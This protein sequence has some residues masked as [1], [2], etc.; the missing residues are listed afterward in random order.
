MLIQKWQNFTRLSVRSHS[1]NARFE[2][3]FTLAFFL[4]CL[5]SGWTAWGPGWANAPKEYFFRV[6]RWNWRSFIGPM[7]VGKKGCLSSS[8]GMEC[9]KDTKCIQTNY[10]T[11]QDS[12]TI[13]IVK[14]SKHHHVDRALSALSL[15]LWA[16]AYLNDVA[17]ERA[18][19]TLLFGIV[20]LIVGQVPGVLHFRLGHIL[21]WEK[22]YFPLKVILTSFTCTVKMRFSGASILSIS[23]YQHL[24][25]AAFIFLIR[26]A[27]YHFLFKW[28]LFQTQSCTE[29]ADFVICHFHNQT[30][31]RLS[32][33]DSIPA[34]AHLLSPQSSPVGC[35]SFWLLI[36]SYSLLMGSGTSSPPFHQEF[37]H[38]T[39][40]LGSFKMSRLKISSDA[41]III[42]LN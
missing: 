22:A 42:D 24:H 18:P 6:D 11:W 12:V 2:Q 34:V 39:K 4:I 33:W 35:G 3:G 38:E 19:Q 40:G 13:F 23:S 25:Y 16:A 1:N 20:E 9:C 32:W 8:A 14:N 36:P 37:L 15:F 26:A 27:F 7:W 17:T 41:H 28:K 29:E 10:N 30:C 31:F 21:S 5:S